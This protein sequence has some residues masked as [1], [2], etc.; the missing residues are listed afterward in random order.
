MNNYRIYQINIAS[1]EDV[2][3]YAFKEWKEAADQFDIN[4]YFESDR[5]DTDESEEE[6][7]KKLLRES[8]KISDVV[9]FNDNF[10]YCNG[11]RFIRLRES[12]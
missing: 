8:V 3:R 7:L 11:D 12:K 10:Y 9:R 6:S 1:I 4:D 2:P 5:H